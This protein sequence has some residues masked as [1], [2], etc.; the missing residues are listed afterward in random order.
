MTR[1]MTK[2]T[3]KFPTQAK[4]ATY[5]YINLPCD[6]RVRLLGVASIPGLQKLLGMTARPIV[7]VDWAGPQFRTVDAEGFTAWRF[8]EEIFRHGLEDAFVLCL[9]DLPS[10]LLPNHRGLS[11]VPAAVHYLRSLVP[12]DAFHFVRRKK[13]K[14]ASPPTSF[15]INAFHYINACECAN[16]RQGETQKVA[17]QTS[18]QTIGLFPFLS[19]DTH[20]RHR[21]GIW[22]Q[23]SLQL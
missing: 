22:S 12:G 15:Y 18:E 2:E 23:Y 21:S 3:G 13:V 4:N 7:S 6:S 8:L 17:A 1:A 11:S 9:R 10:R 5:G 14:C 16:E 19:T 20:R